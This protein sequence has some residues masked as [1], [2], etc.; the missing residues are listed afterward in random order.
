M[1][2]IIYCNKAT[3]TLHYCQWFPAEPRSVC[4]H[5][6]GF[7]CARYQSP[8]L[9]TPPLPP[10]HVQSPSYPHECISQKHLQQVNR[11][12]GC[13]H[14]SVCGT[15]QRSRKRLNKGRSHVRAR[16]KVCGWVT[17]APRLPFL[18]SPREEASRFP[19]RPLLGVCRMMCRMLPM[20]GFLYAPAPLE[21]AFSHHADHIRARVYTHTQRCVCVCVNACAHNLPL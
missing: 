15:G 6:P 10:Q 19:W 20:I 1:Y 17:A 5:T 14:Q 13:V 18:I 11:G 21:A 3:S 16:R 9:T 7:C 8:E 2:T 12:A 4:T